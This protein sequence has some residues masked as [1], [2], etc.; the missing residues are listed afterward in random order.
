MS[1]GMELPLRWLSFVRADERGN[2]R[3][4]MHAVTLLPDVFREAFHQRL[5]CTADLEPT[6]PIRNLASSQQKLNEKTSAC[7][8]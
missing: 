6:F 5:V 1:L 7:C 2:D 3:L 8:V 4:V